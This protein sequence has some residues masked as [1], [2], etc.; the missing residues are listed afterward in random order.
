MK[1]EEP[2]E[3]VKR[4]EPSETVER[5][6]PSETAN[7][8]KEPPQREEPKTS[9]ATMEQEPKAP[10]QPEA[11]KEQQNETPT[12]QDATS[13]QEPPKP[14]PAVKRYQVPSSRKPIPP[15]AALT[16]V[17]NG[18][19]IHL[20][21]FRFDKDACLIQVGRAG[22]YKSFTEPYLDCCSICVQ[23]KDKD[24]TVYTHEEVTVKQLKQYT[25]QV[26]LVRVCES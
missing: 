10:E 5:E 26:P 18:T 2:S 11:G 25:M 22:E 14:P 8:K 23:Y 4:E 19:T 1:R 13:S 6:E 16:A 20:Q 24:Y 7:E 21:F 17:D 3:P 12:P 15:T 9:N